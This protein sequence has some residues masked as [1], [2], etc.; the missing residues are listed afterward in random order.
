MKMVKRKF[1]FYSSRDEKLWFSYPANPRSHHKIEKEILVGFACG[2]VFH[3]SHLRTTFQAGQEDHSNPDVA[4]IASASPRAHPASHS[5]LSEDEDEN[6]SLSRTVG[7]KV[8][9]AR[10]IR[11]QIGN[12]CPICALGEEVKNASAQPSNQGGHE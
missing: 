3:L 1:L 2:H 7:P 5:F 6:M 12:G 8:I 10:L 11:D 9:T 4:E